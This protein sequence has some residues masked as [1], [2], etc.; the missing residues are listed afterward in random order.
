MRANK[1][2][3]AVQDCWLVWPHHDPFNTCTCTHYEN[4]LGTHWTGYVY[5]CVYSLLMRANKLKTAVK[6]SLACLVPS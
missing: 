1:L 4:P 2:K 5:R 6:Q 3:T